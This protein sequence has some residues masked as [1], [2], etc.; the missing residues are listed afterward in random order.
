MRKNIIV[1]S[2]YYKH[3]HGKMYAPNTTGLFSYAE[4][5][6]GVYD[7]GILYGLQAW[8]MDNLMTPLTKDD[9]DYAEDIVGGMGGFD[10][11]IWDRVVNKHGGYAPVKIQAVKEGINVPVRNVLTTVESTDRELFSLTSFIETALIRLWYPTTI[12]TKAAVMR[13]GIDQLFDTYADSKASRDFPLLDFGCRGVTCY[14]QAAI[15]GGA[16]LTSFIGSDT[17]PG[18]VY[19][20][21]FYGA[22]VSGFSVPATE[23]SVMCSYG[24]DNEFESFKHLLEN[25]AKENG[26]ISIV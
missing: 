23:H 24:Q 13:R 8:I 14:E 11:A 18:V 12:A 22:K 2:D 9:V 7:F 20:R 1:D 26:I 25:V 3:T 10:R 19:N 21:E 17:C 4:S 15:G 16:F 6:G 5:R